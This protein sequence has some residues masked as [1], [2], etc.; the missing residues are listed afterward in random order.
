MGKKVN[1]WICGTPHDFC[2][3]CGQTHGWRYVADTIECYNI[4]IVIEQY[5]SGVFT[6]S[7]AIKALADKCDISV[8]TDISWMIPEVAETIREIIGEKTKT[9]KKSKL[10]QD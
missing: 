1:C 7:D 10:Y 4:Y 9:T 2:P 5:K 6:K 3:T 8:D